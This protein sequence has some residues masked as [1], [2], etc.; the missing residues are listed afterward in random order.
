MSLMFIMHFSWNFSW[1]KDSD[2]SLRMAITASASWKKEVSGFDGIMT[3]KPRMEERSSHYS[4]TL[5]SAHFSFIYARIALS[6]LSASEA[7]PFSSA[8]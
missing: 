1:G 5:L 2:F 7:S 8:T 3:M 6:K 4:S